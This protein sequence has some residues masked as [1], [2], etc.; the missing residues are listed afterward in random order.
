MSISTDHARDPSGLAS[1]G[2][3]RAGA[4]LR[5]RLAG[6]WRRID[7]IGFGRSAAVA[8][9]V[10][11]ASAGL[12]YLSQIVLARWMGGF[13]YGVYVAVWT[14]VLVLGGV[15]SLGLA[16]LS[17]R[18][19]AEHRERGEHDRLRGLLLYGRLVPMGV[20]TLVA[21]AALGALHVGGDLLSQPF[22]L[23]ATI[24]LF[25]VPIIA[26]SDV[27][28]GIGRGRGWMS[29][30]LLPPYVLRPLLVL[31]AMWLAH[32]L[33][34]PMTAATAAGAAVVGT[35]GAAAVQTLTLSRKLSSE[36]PRGPALAPRGLWLASSLPLLA[37]T[38]GEL[39]LQNTDI[40]VVSQL[41]GPAEAGVYFAA[42]KTMSLVMFV[43]YAV[44]SAMAG[45]FAELNARGDREGLR[46]AVRRAVQW[47]FWPS[48]AAALVLLALGRPL[49]WL[50]GPQ[51]EAG[52][53]VMLVLVVGFLGRAAMGPSE[54]LLSMLGQQRAAAVA[55]LAVVALNLALSFALVPMLGTLGA[56]AATATSL[57]AGAALTRG[58][59][60]RKLGLGIA[61]WQ[62]HGRRPSGH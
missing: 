19:V 2:A 27:Q 7:T 3:P 45:R 29:V 42:A 18:L 35:W 58:I 55:A 38:F 33:G 17:M 47:T 51:F 6:L 1:A 22:V 5:A 60:S 9:S 14:W 15:S 20:A 40:L 43:H 49:L 10:R 31:A 32:D 57:I 46:L 39:M 54:L 26:L 13:E 52:Y 48:L 36:L 41:L 53:P 34:W 16:T 24:A 37:T 56:A 30:A 44:G 28:D 21:G 12:L 62:N 4:C 61:I 23:P 25:C 50:F 59:A 8:F 11:V